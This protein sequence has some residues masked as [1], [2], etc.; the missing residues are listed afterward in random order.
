MTDTASTLDH[1]DVAGRPVAFLE[2][3]L[4]FGGSVADTPVYAVECPPYLEVGADRVAETRRTDID[5]GGK[6]AFL[7]DGVLDAEEAAR[8]TEIT[9]GLGYR[10]EAPGIVTAPGLRQN[11]SV[12]WVA[13]DHT[14]AVIYDRLA[15]HLPAELDGQKLVPRL[16][17][18]LN[19]YRYDRGDVFNPHIDGDWPGFG[20]SDDGQAMVQWPGVW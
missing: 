3:S 19:M 14:L 15:P 20:L 11:K 13:D 17:R 5:M 2:G 12:H 1:S 16:S 7:V 9:E 18:R 4:P 8:M 6:L 10:P